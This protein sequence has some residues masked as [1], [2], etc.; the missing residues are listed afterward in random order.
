MGALKMAASPA[1]F[2]SIRIGTRDL[3]LNDYIYLLNA[4]LWGL[5]RYNLYRQKCLA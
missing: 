1:M 5:T 2:V 4:Q 3:T